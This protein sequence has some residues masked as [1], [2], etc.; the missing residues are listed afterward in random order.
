MLE[1]AMGWVC[2]ACGT[3]K[4]PRVSSCDC[5]QK[6]QVTKQTLTD[7]QL[8]GLKEAKK[9]K[10]HLSL[11]L[12]YWKGYYAALNTF[13]DPKST[14]TVQKKMRVALEKGYTNV[15]EYTKLTKKE[16]DKIK[17]ILGDQ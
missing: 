15:V 13:H 9:A 10:S 14:A 12:E 16:T 4:S 17:Q 2:P 8:I 1:S 6:T 5:N 3:P 7:D 11:G